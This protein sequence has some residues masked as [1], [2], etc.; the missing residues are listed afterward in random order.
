MIAYSPVPLR[1]GQAVLPMV[2]P[3][4]VVPPAAPDAVTA[5]KSDLA[6]L[7]GVSAVS[8]A[9]TAGGTWVGIHTGLKE[10]GFLSFTGWT[11]GILSG[12]GVLTNLAS[13]IVTGAKIAR[14]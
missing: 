1:L 5:S 13:L 6:I 14:G 4:P 3:M 12:V 8:L 7:A 9:L 2:S 11:V 10:R